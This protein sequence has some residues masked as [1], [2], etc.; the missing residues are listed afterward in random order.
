MSFTKLRLS[1]YYMTRTIQVIDYKQHLYFCSCHNI[2]IYCC[3]PVK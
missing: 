2:K 1:I 3:R